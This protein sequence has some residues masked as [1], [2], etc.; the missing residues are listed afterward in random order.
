MLSYTIH[1]DASL[2]TRSLIW[3]NSMRKLHVKRAIVINLS[4]DVIFDYLSNLEHLMDWS[5]AILSVKMLSET[6]RLGATASI[7]TRFLGKQSEL[8]LETVEYQPNQC[9]LIKS[10]SGITPCIFY[11]QFESLEDGSTSVAQDAAFSF[12]SSFTDVSERIV[13]NAIHRQLDYD[14]LTLKDVL[15]TRTPTCSTTS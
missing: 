2:I 4:A 3:S 13:T 15:E 8:V 12:I 11:Y 9:F 6:T 5:S 7:T 1:T 14:L 10:V